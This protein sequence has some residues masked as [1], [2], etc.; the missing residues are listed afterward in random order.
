MAE[1]MTVR[2]NSGRPSVRSTWTQLSDV[3]CCLLAR[4]FRLF[5]NSPVGIV[6]SCHH[7][8]HRLRWRHRLTCRARRRGRTHSSNF[9]SPGRVLPEPRLNRVCARATFLL[10][11]LHDAA[12]CSRASGALLTGSRELAPAFYGGV[13]W[14]TESGPSITEWRPITGVLPPLSRAEWGSWFDKY[15]STPEFRLC[16]SFAVHPCL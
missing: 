5:P 7:G 12:S 11:Q 8:L 16:A 9:P 10:I 4:T 2:C 14:L 1:N 13:T 6:S 15:R 3:A